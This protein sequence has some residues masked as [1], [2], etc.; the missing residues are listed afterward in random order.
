MLTAA[1][2]KNSARR[3]MCWFVKPEQFDEIDGL[4][5]PGGESSS[6]LKTSWR[7]ETFKS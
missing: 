2:W 4:V 3:T 1:G 5:I 7:R 6:F